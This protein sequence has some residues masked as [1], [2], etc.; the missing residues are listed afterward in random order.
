MARTLILKLV[1]F[2]HSR[3]VGQKTDE[4]K[5]IVVGENNMVIIINNK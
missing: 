2:L 5:I 3:K 4:Q 1:G